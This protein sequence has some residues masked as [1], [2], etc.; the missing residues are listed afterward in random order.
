MATGRH[1][2]QQSLVAFRFDTSNVIYIA[3]QRLC[4]QEDPPGER[5]DR[6]AAAVAV[7]DRR[8]RTPRTMAAMAETPPTMTRTRPNILITGTPGAGK[9]NTSSM[10]AVSAWD[11]GPRS[12]AWA[13]PHPQFA[14]YRRAPRA[15]TQTPGVERGGMG[16][17][18]ARLSAVAATMTHLTTHD[19]PPTTHDPPPTTHHPTTHHPTTH[20]PTTHHPT[21][22]PPQER[23]GLRHV[24]CSELVKSEGCHEGWDEEFQ[25]YTLDED[26]LCDVLEPMMAEGGI[27]VD[28]HR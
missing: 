9:T 8:S 24:E 27:V 16:S 3:L 25:S 22:H 18:R 19:P 14:D 5:I 7:I 20:H 23:T 2:S 12:G 26:K 28:F 10:V 11:W 4:A 1:S 15:G 13:R 17:E 6:P 21:T